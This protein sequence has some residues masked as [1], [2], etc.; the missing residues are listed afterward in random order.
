M[1]RRH[2]PMIVRTYIDTGAIACGSMECGAEPAPWCR[3][4]DGH[5]RRVPHLRKY[6][7]PRADRLPPR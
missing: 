3:K 1:K 6:S 2:R 4:P 7:T 5:D